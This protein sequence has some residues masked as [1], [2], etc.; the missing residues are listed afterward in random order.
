MRADGSKI[1][2]KI[3][4]SLNRVRAMRADGSKIECVLHV[5]RRNDEND[6]SK[7][8]WNKRTAEALCTLF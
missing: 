7:T 1:E 4:I 6:E 8:I 5:N 2:I 3:S